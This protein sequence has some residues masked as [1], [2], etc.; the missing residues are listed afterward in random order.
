MRYQYAL[1]ALIAIIASAAGAQEPAQPPLAGAVTIDSANSGW[2][3]AGMTPYD[4]PEC[5]NGAGRAGG[6]G[7]TASY[8]FDGTGVDLYVIRGESI[9]VDGRLHKVG[10]IAVKLDNQFDSEIAISYATTQHRYLA[11][12]AQDLPPG[13]HTIH[14]SPV[15]GWAVIDYLTIT[16]SKPGAAT[17]VVGK[18]SGPS[19]PQDASVSSELG[20]TSNVTLV[21]YA[22]RTLHGKDNAQPVATS[23]DRLDEF[24]K[25]NEWVKYLQFQG[26]SAGVPYFGTR[27]YQLPAD[28]DVSAVKRIDVQVNYLGPLAERQSWTWYLFDW[29]TQTWTPIGS[30]AGTVG[31]DHWS[32]LSF[33]VNQSAGQ[34]VQPGGAL[35]L[36]TASNNAADDADIDYEAVTVT[37][38]KSGLG[39]K[40]D[41]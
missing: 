32:T 20:P 27:S 26:R 38:A 1:F 24:G 33:T 11:F 34:L 29:T 31:W 21:P 22:Y 37:F 10:R 23:I 12:S 2:T 25:T 15:A 18:D 28:I 3:W 40:S 19:R 4:D 8:T 35:L 7:T 41:N 36:A 9:A 14:I 5:L 30:N 39:R 6:P 17:A 13:Q 16:P